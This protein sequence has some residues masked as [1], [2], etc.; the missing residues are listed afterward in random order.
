MRG[1][2]LLMVLV[3]V[4]AG[5]GSGSSNTART[6][7]TTGVQGST[8]TDSPATAAWVDAAATGV[9]RAPGLHVSATDAHC[10]GRAL[11]DTVTV[12]KLEAAGVTAAA[13]ADP[14]RDLPPSLGTSLDPAT[15]TALG[16]AIQGCGG[17]VFGALVAQGF[18]QGIN[19]SYKPDAATRACAQQWFSS[20]ARQ[21]IVGDAVLNVNPTAA[22]AS[23]IADLIVDCF[24]VAALFAPQFHVT[25]TSAETSC[26]NAT[27]RTSTQFHSALVS[28]ITGKTD[29]ATTTAEELFGASIMKCLTPEHILQISKANG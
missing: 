7:S 20:P 22:D 15:K 5:C 26:I 25:F 9:E 23:Q 17:G 16:A 11:V 28:E 14:N 10:L 3:F 27:A 4:V 8:T 24:N 12:G 1:I 13:L 2:L 6:T 18:A 21:S 19:N 29:S